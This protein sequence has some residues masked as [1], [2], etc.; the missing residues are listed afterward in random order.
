M[1][2][3]MPDIEIIEKTYDSIDSFRR[4]N[5]INEYVLSFVLSDME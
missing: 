1:G 4:Y 3:K 5:G 2:F